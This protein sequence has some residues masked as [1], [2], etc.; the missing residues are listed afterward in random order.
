MRFD[1]RRR[2]GQ[3]GNSAILVIEPFALL[4]ALGKLQP[5]LTPYP[6]YLLVIN[7]PAFNREQLG[8]LAIAIAAILFG[9]L[10][11]GQSQGLIITP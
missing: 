7:V 11:Q 2:K 3:P 8:N 1:A 4:M 10:D 5:F 9:Q 6:L